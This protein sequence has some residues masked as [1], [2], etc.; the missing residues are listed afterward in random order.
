MSDDSKNEWVDDEE[1]SALTMERQVHPDESSEDQARRLLKENVGSAV[2]GIV[3]TSQH[4]SS[5]RIRLD[6]QKYIIDRVLGK[7]G[8]DI[9]GG[10]NDPLERFLSGVEAMA[11]KGV[12]DASE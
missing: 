5:D 2:L 6:A 1:L 8:E 3:H 7:I 10:G 11:N 12:S 4:G 9:N